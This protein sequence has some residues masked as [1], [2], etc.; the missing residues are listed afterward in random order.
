MSAAADNPVLALAQAL[1]QRASVTP[2][3]AGCQA[4]LV[5]RLQACGFHIHNLP[6]GEVENLWALRGNSGPL[7][8]FAGHTDVVP[9]GDLAKWNC[10]PFQPQIRDGLLYGRGAADMKSSLAAM[11]VAVERF[12]AQHP[13][14]RGRIGFLITSDE[15]GPSINGTR[16]VVEWLAEQGEQIDYCIVGEPSSSQRLADTIKN[17]RRGSLGAKLSINGKQ[18]HV[19]YPHLALNPIHKAAAFMA[20]LCA[21]Q[22]DAGNEHFPPTCLQITNV[23]AGVGA[24]N[25]IP[26]SLNLQFNL[27]FSTETSEALIRQRVEA[28]LQQH[29]LDHEIHW[30][31]SGLPFLTR[32]GALL[33][34]VSQA[35]AQQCGYAPELSTAGG[36]SDG[37]FIAPTGAEVVELGPVNA[38]IHKINEHVA[39]AD[40]EPLAGIYQQ[41]L[42]NL[43]T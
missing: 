23:Q 15:E 2:D 7:L 12:C 11:V 41:T 39:V 14:H 32:P 27:R 43:L 22:W 6:F 20:E 4:L 9:P 21:L 30:R 19:A 28:L 33:N 3:D 10:D 18:G 38:S 5:E 25:V 40:L 17:G 36:T 37:R 13:Q 26:G 34:A 24:D 35:V 1:I 42:V 8:V 31:L 29:G 16:K